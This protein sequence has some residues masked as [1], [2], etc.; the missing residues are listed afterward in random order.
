MVRTFFQNTVWDAEAGV[1]IDLGSVWI[2]P[3]DTNANAL[4]DDWEE[5][6]FSG[7]G[8]VGGDEDLDGDGKSNL[9]E[10]WSG[11]DPT[12]SNDLFRVY[13]LLHTNSGVDVGWSATPWR[14]YRLSVGSMTGTGEWLAVGTLEA[15]PG[16]SNIVWHQYVDYGCTRARIPDRIAPP[17]FPVACVYAAM[18]QRTCPAHVVAAFPLRNGKDM[19]RRSLSPDVARGP[20]RGRGSVARR[21]RPLFVHVRC[22]LG[23]TC[24]GPDRPKKSI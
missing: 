14:H 18:R 6:F 20:R 10:Y 17:P 2:A 15:G 13:S 24:I 4:A 7:I 5:A 1:Q 9:E 3:A 19:R 8:D 21:S 12:N 23:Q 11:T 22:A 16:P